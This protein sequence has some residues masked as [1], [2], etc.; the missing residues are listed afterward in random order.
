MSNFIYEKNLELLDFIREN[1]KKGYDIYSNTEDINELIDII[2]NWYKFK[3]PDIEL[4]KII[5]FQRY[6]EAILNFNNICLFSN[7]GYF[8]LM[9]RIPKNLH[10]IIEC[11]Y[12]KD[13]IKIELKDT[14]NIVEQKININRYDGS[15]KE[16]PNF[17]ILKNL[18]FDCKD[19]DDF[20]N[21]NNN[22]NIDEEFDL[23]QP[24]KLAF[25]HNL[26]LELRKKYLI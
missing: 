10:Q 12:I 7:M 9:K 16:I 25:T 6:N 15:F 1:V 14:C 20:L 5:E 3:Y 18:N 2:V 17:R 19:I 24:K 26:N 23:D 4:I 8:E 21:N 13:Y 22:K 11:W